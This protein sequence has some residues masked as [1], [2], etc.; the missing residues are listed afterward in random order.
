LDRNSVFAA[1]GLLRPAAHMTD[2]IEKTDP[3]TSNRRSPQILLA[4]DDEDTRTIIAAA[5]RRSGYE[6][7]EV[8]TGAE[9]L[10]HV[11]AT[12][13][14]RDLSPPPDLIVSDIRMPGFTGTGVLAGLRD[15]DIDMPFILM[16]AYGGAE[17]RRQ[18]ENLGADALFLKPFDIDEFLKTVS[19]LIPTAAW[20]PRS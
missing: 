3:N 4:E 12:L 11:G 9:L 19:S 18:S 7:V 20:S 8:K 13:L 2:S 14:F 16:T 10:E 17:A 5:L 1:C 6:V 15:A